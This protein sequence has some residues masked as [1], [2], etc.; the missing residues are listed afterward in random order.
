MAAATVTNRRDNV[1]GSRRM[2]I[3]TLAGAG[4]TP[5]TWVTGL[6]TIVGWSVD[7][8]SANP[9]TVVTVSGGTLTITAA[10]AYTGASGIVWGY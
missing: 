7:A 3:A 10:G 1:S 4:S 6:K 9:P 2:V 8:G 5:D